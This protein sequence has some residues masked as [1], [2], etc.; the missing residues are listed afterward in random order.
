[1][2]KNYKFKKINNNFNKFN[3]TKNI[4]LNFYKSLNSS[5]SLNKLSTKNY[6]K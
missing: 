6:T 4:N 3:D 1:M 5:S 2:I